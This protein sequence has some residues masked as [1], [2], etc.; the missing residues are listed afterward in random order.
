MSRHSPRPARDRSTGTAGGLWL[1]SLGRD[2]RTTPAALLLVLALAG[3]AGGPLPSGAGEPT[4]ASL[5]EGRP[6]TV[7]DVVDGDTMDVRYPDGSTERVRLLGVD[8]PEVGGRV[9]PAEFEGVPDTE[10]GRAWLREWGTRASEFARQELDG[11]T[12]RVVTDPAS[13]VRGDYGRLLVYVRHDGANF[14]RRLL[15][16]GHARLYDA[17]FSRRPAFEA[18]ETEAQAAGVGVWGFDGIPDTEADADLAVVEIHA[19]AA[20]DDNENLDDEYVVFENAGDGPLDLSGWQVGDEAGHTYVFP[21]GFTLPA[22]QRVRLRTGDGTD[23]DADLYW[24]RNGAVWN[25]DGDT[26]TVRTA[27]GRV[28]VERSYG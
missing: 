12:V 14:N 2:M 11:E 24:R 7:A 8:S 3:C 25:N 21:D 19:D 17:Q 28:V 18:A 10:A 20:G 23:T 13:D 26:V 22:G 9:T 4:P 5:E 27:D 16:T 1:P 6:V 15:E